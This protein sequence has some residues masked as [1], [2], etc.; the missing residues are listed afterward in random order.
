MPTYSMSTICTNCGHRYGR[1]RGR[2]PAL[3][4]IVVN[5]ITEGFLT[6]SYPYTKV[7]SVKPKVKI[8]F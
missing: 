4:P 8:C 5:G 3:C 2:E 1:H 7:F 6:P